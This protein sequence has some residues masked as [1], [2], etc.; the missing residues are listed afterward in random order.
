MKT[1]INPKT[2]REEFW[3]Q[4][5]KLQGILINRGFSNGSH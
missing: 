4:H 5:L 2:G 1:R 3:N